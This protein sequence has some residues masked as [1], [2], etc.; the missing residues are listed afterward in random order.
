MPDLR[1]LTPQVRGVVEHAYGLGTGE[2]FLI[3]VP[4]AVIALI[5]VVLM[6]EVPLG[7]KSGIRLR[8]ERE[9]L[10][11]WDAETVPEPGDGRPAEAPARVSAPRS[12]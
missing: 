9:Q 4:L 12:G 5:A 2:I 3:T 8:A 11:E 1:T 6:K 10:P 7:A